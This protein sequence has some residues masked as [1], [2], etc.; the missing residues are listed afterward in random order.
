MLILLSGMFWIRL[1]LLSSDFYF[2][3]WS[4][5]QLRLKILTSL[6]WLGFLFCSYS[7]SLYI[8]F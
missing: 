4:N 5:A 1:R 8:M 2:L 6:L 7:I 3:T